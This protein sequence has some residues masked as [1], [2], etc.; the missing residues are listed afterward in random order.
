MACPVTSRTICWFSAG[1]ASA[2]ATM[3]TLA[4]VGRVDT[5]VV[6]T[7]PG[8]EHPDNARFIN[9]CETWFHHGITRLRSDKYRDTWQVWEERRFIVSPQGA[10]CTTELKKKIR[11][12]FQQP[13]DIQVFGYTAEEQHR[14]DR[15]REQNPE[16]D[17]RTPL[18][19]RSLSKAD[20]LGI[21]ERAGI[22]LPAMYLLGYRNNN[23]VG[24]P[25]GGIGYWNTIRRDFPAVFDRMA[26]LERDIGHSVLSDA[27]GPVWL[28][29]L[30]PLRGDLLTEPDIEC[31]LLCAGTEQM[32]TP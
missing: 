14:A 25:K 26:A 12:Q 9:D 16:V 2:V 10:L 21:I 28:D 18:I 17:L 20:C 4:E 22:A 1:A 31:S 19:E 6:Y 24:C 3:L 27:A 29:M 7:D 23:C 13:D 8:S 11:Q 32:W 15:F 5:V 30:D